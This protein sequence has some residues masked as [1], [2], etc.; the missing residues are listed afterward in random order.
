MDKQFEL[1]T[2]I[3]NNILQEI[4]ACS[5]QQLVTIPAGFNNHI[6]WNAIHVIVSQQILLYSRTETPFRVGQAIIEDYRRGTT[7]SSVVNQ[8]MIDFVKN[9]LLATVAIVKGDYYNKAFGPYQHTT[10][11]FGA[12]LNTIEDAITFNNL[13]E[14]MHYGQIKMLRK[15]VG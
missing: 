5:D 14:S 15:L 12:T 7:P 3:R 13:H 1:L 6:L 10:T 11:S 4:D 8:G 2:I 9:N